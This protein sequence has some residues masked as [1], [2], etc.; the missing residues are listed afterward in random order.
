MKIL[1]VC[2]GNICRSPLAEGILKQKLEAKNISSVT[3]DSC[4]TANYHAGQSPDQRTQSNALTH[5]TDLSSLRARQFVV[6]DFDT[7]DKIFVMDS[8]NR[9][10][11][12]KLSRNKEDEHKIELLLNITH[13]KKNLAVPDPYF[14]GPTGFE[15][16]YQLVDEACDTLAESLR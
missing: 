4:G 16:V 5:G 12:L 14:G 9:E 6:G 3:V 8:S 2:L 10:N 13:P 1:M 15:D 7:F 11:V